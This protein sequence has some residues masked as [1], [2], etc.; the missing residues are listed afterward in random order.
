M[1][2]RNHGDQHN[3]DD[4]GTNI[5]PVTM[6]SEG[7]GEQHDNDDTGSVI[8]L[9]TMYLYDNPAFLR[10]GFSPTSNYATLPA[11]ENVYPEENGVSTHR[12]TQAPSPRPQNSPE[13]QSQYP[14]SFETTKE[15]TWAS[16]TQVQPYPPTQ[17]RRQSLGHPVEVPG[18][19][20][21]FSADTISKKMW[22]AFWIR[23]TVLWVLAVT[24]LVCVAALVILRHYSLVGNGFFISEATSHYLWTYGPTFFIVLVASLWRQ[25]D[26]HCRTVAP[27]VEL[28]RG[29]NVAP[30]VL[31]DDYISPMPHSI[32][33]IAI[34]KRRWPIVIST[35]GQ[36]LFKVL[37]STTHMEAT[38]NCIWN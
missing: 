16:Y 5:S 20:D 19:R 27:W 11:D 15:P 12:A 26:M 3:N 28:Q 36:V 35:I 34:K 6:S 4:A 8:S 33:Y 29:D 30:G 18:L 1:S 9:D 2:F 24:Y 23:P 13:E 14:S 17:S 37:V 32:V 31:Q 22:T 25:V 10:N 38:P 21:D 7:H